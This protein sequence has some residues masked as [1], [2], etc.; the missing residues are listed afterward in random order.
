[1]GYPCP[2]LDR[3]ISSPRVLAGMLKIKHTPPAG[4]AGLMA[5]PVGF[6]PTT[7]SL[8]GSCSRPLSYGTMFVMTG[9]GCAEVR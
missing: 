6:E 7:L 4:E 2:D 5:I 8:E 9:A 1:M 3:G